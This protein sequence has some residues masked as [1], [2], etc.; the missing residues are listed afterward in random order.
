MIEQD[1]I[2]LM[3]Q[4][5]DGE[6]SA[7]GARKLADY[8]ATNPAAREYF[9]EL[10]DAVQIFQKIPLIDPPP[11]L[12]DAVMA[13]VGPDASPSPRQQPAGRAPAAWREWFQPMRAL[14]F[15]TGALFGLILFAGIARFD[16]QPADSGSAWIQGT[17]S[18]FLEPN[19]QWAGALGIDLP[20]VSGQVQSLDRENGTLIHLTLTSDAPVQVRFSFDDPVVFE[21]YRAAP[22]TVHAVAAAAGSTVIEHQGEGDYHLLFAHPAGLETAV[23]VDLQTQGGSRTHLTVPAAK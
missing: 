19:R 21:G 22:G 15:A 11:G 10:Q 23:E 8:L 3:N 18:G 5:L 16:S 13:S 20:G 4:E 6:N 7:G 2:D 9:G 17:A 14:T 12:L 1:Y